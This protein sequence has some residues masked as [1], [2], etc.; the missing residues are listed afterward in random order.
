[1]FIEKLQEIPRDV[2]FNGFAERGLNQIMFLWRLRFLDGGEEGLL[3]EYSKET[4]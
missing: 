4:L 1:V 2:G 3:V